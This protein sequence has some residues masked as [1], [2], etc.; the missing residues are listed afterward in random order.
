MMTEFAV[1][2]P[3]ASR[4]RLVADSTVELKAENGWWR[5]EAE[6]TDYAFL[7]DDS[8]Q[9]LPD[10]RSKWQPD[11]VHGRSRVYDQE[12][13]YGTDQQ[14]PGKALPGSI[15]Y[16]LHVGTFTEAGTF[17]AAKEKLDHL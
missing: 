4:V 6:G 16:E 15:I 8:D 5:G 11:G 2:A 14:W 9:E 17:D 7:V 12:P 3:S 1:W 13:F 10:P